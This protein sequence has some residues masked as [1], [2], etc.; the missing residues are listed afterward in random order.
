MNLKQ[1]LKKYQNESQEK[2]PEALKAIMQASAQK[3]IDEKVGEN[4]L[5]VGDKLPKGTLV[6]AVN[7]PVDI[8]DCL[9]KGP[10][11]ISFYR[12]AWCP[13]CNLELLAYKEILPE[14]KALGANF[15]AIS[16]ELPD[17]SMTLV[18]KHGLEF[19]VLTDV[20]NAYARELGLV[21]RVDD[22]LVEVYKKIGIDME[23]SQGNANNEIPLPA[24]FVID[25]DGTVILANVDTDYT[26][27]LEPS[28]TVKA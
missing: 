27:R 1:E 12:G 10:L 9:A 23:A 22:D 5:K 21:F 26:K 24:T 2:R 28:E 11:V 25:Q 19:E 6:N 14:I 7:T 20:D 13:Y 18:E 4:A 8:Y 3:L 17:H 16:P 15:V